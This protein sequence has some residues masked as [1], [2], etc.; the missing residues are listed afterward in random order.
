MREDSHPN[1]HAAEKKLESHYTYLITNKISVMHISVEC[2]RIKLLFVKLTK[3]LWKIV[4]DKIL[5]FEA[6]K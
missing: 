3:V 5:I 4:S 2:E 1:K 6:P